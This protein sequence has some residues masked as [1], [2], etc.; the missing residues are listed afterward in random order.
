MKKLRDLE[1][2]SKYKD[3][4]R[5]VA[6]VQIRHPFL[7]LA[8]ILAIT[9]LLLGGVSKVKTVASL[10]KMMPSD[11]EEIK[12][13]NIMRDNFLG[14]DMIAVVLEMDFESTITNS[15]DVTSYE[16]YIYVKKLKFAFSQQDNVVA[17]YAFSD[18]I[19]MYAASMYVGKKTISEEEYYDLL[20]NVEVQKQI[21][22]FINFEKT[23]S[24]I[25]VTTDISADDLRMNLLSDNIR[26]DIS[27]AGNP[28]STNI[29]ITGTPIIQQKLGEVIEHDRSQTEKY[30]AIF[31][32]IVV[33]IIFGSFVTAIVPMV[34]II[35]SII[36]LYGLMGYC[37]LPISTLAGGVA[38]MVIGIGVDY[39][40]H[41][42]N[43]FEYERKKG[44]SL[45]YAV[46]ETMGNTGYVLTTVTIVTAIAF[47]T[48]LIGD[49]PEM[50]RFGL[51]MTMGVGLAFILSVV[52]LPALF[53]VEEK[54]INYVK[55]NFKFGAKQE[56]V[57]TEENELKKKPKKEI[58]NQIKLKNKNN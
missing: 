47:L 36:W 51:L 2:P 16:Y 54:L 58:N 49:M 35:L 48:F 17:T 25:L 3:F 19:D 42:R 55:T 18:V 12:S 32:F 39:S 24:I 22:R 33:A 44:E 8:L 26:Q 45:E 10:E 13:F 30:S 53:I 56:I 14:Q 15:Y 27:S 1:K 46:E 31:V 23:N 40:I 29:H 7:T 52:G 50:G 28:G 37:G 4:L 43:K 9:I 57:L 5:A 34:T 38:A 41:L 20:K 11:V 21:S 6:R